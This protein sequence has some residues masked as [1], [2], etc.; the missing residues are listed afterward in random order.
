[1]SLRDDENDIR[2]L[3]RSERLRNRRKSRSR[4]AERHESP[5]PEKEEAR[6]CR[7]KPTPQRTVS[8]FD[9]GECIAVVVFALG[10]F[11]FLIKY[12]SK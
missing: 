11:W 4:S 2:P 3:R 10:Y 8:K 9:I 7:P 12:L 5:D 6:N 1:M